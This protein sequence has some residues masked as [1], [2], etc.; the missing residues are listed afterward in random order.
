VKRH[1]DV[2]ELISIW[3]KGVPFVG[4]DGNDNNSLLMRGGVLKLMRIA[5]TCLPAL[6]ARRVE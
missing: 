2:D 1:I 5:L 6:R 4:H 3:R